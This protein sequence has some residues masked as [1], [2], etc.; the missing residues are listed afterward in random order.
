MACAALV[1]LSTR[2]VRLVL[3]VFCIKCCCLSVLHCRTDQRTDC[4]CVC[5]VQADKDAVHVDQEEHVGSYLE[6]QQQLAAA[7]AAMRAV[8]NQPRYIL[9][10]LQPG[11]LVNIA[12][13][14]SGTQRSPCGNSVLQ[15]GLG[16]CCC[17]GRHKASI[18]II[19]I[20]IKYYCCYCYIVSTGFAQWW[21]MA[22]MMSL[23]A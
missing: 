6:L 17:H 18:M 5:V 13:S 16:E 11:R 4:V 10:F 20:I 23:L 2:S 1:R 3:P 14:A 12:A 9:P 19:I 15:W 8:V 22:G 7:K 21:L